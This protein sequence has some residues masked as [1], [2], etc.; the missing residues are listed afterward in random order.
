[1]AGKLVEMLAGDWR[2]EEQEDTY[3]DAV[4]RMIEQK[5]KGRKPK[6][7][8]R[9]PQ[10]GDDLAAALEASLEG[11]KPKR[12]ASPKKKKATS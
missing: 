5:R 7:A 8:K 10:T 3:R 9:R 11:G 1:M 4:L 6:K 2:P 12:K